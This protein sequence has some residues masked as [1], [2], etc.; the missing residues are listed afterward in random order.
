MK[1]TI[2]L[3]QETKDTFEKAR[4]K[5][6]V[7]ERRLITQDEFIKILMETYKNAKIS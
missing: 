6:K 3:K 2:Q 4:F 7:K 1:Q 5:L